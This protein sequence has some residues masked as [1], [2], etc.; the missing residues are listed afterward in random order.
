[1]DSDGSHDPE[2]IERLIVPILN[3]ADVVLGSR[4]A[5]GQGKN[6]TK[7]L[8]VFGNILINFLIRIMTRKYVTDSQTGFR[9]YRKKVLQEIDITSEGY[10][11]ETELTVKV[12]KNGNV[13]KEVPIK[14]NKRMNGCS[15]LNPLTDGFQIF[16]TIV[17]SSMTS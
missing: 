9:A 6:S 4:F 2:D 17:K 12:L 10:H 11:V 8:H 16:K 15:R 3:G 14:I 1:M 7:R 13:L 5:A